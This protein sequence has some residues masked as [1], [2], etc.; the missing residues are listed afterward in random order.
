MKKHTKI[1]L[2]FFNYGIED[3]I[4]CEICASKGVDIHHIDARGMGGSKSKDVIENLMCLCRQ[5]HSTFGDIKHHK[6]YLIKIHSKH[7]KR[8]QN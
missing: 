7:L 8:C 5:C 4:P 6:E 3:F 1:Y 2:E